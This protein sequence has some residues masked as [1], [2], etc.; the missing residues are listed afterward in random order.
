MTTEYIKPYY[1]NGTLKENARA[2]FRFQVI[3]RILLFLL[4]MTVL[5]LISAFYK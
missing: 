3:I 1:T 2:H 5:F 4:I